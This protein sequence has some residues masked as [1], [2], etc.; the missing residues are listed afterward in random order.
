MP[1]NTNTKY[2]CVICGEEHSKKSVNNNHLKSEK[3]LKNCEILKLNLQMKT[4]DDI[5][6]DYPEYLEDVNK[7][8][9]KLDLINTIVKDKSSVKIELEKVKTNDEVNIDIKMNSN[10]SNKEAL[11]EKIH[12]IHN[13]LRNNGAGYG[14]AALKVFNIFYGL[15]RIEENKLFNKLDLSDECKFSYLLEK[16]KGDDDVLMNI[17]YNQVLESLSKSKLRYFLFYEIPTNMKGKIF[18]HLI[19]ELD[20]LTEIEKSYGE[21]LTGKIYE[22]FIGRDKQAI[23]ELGAYFTN[24]LIVEYIYKQLELEREEDGSIGTMVDPFGGSGGFTTGYINWMKEKYEDI[25]WSSEINKIH[26]YDMNE[27]VIK[28]AALEFF[29]IT[30][31]VPNMEHLQYKNSFTDEFNDQQ[32]KYCITNPPYG[33]DKNNKSDA[34]KK[35]EKIKKYI[36]EELKTLTDKDIIKRRNEQ[37]KHID[38]LNK[39][40]KK[41]QDEQKVTLEKSSKR[42]KKFAK[43]YGLK[44]NDKEAVSLM[45][46]MDMVEEGGVGCGVLKEGV[47]FNKTYKNLRKCLLENYNVTKV[48][49]IPSDQFENT[50]TKTSIVI[51]KNTEEKT[52]SVQFYDLSCVKYDKDKLEEIDGHIVLTENEG[53]VKGVEDKLVSVANVQDI[54]NQKD[55]SLTGK[56]YNKIDIIPGDGY[57]LVRLGDICNLTGRGHYT[58]IGKKEGKYRFY[59]SS[60]NSKLYVDFCDIQELSI[61]LGQG[62][63]FNIH[64]DSNFTPSKHVCVLQLNEKNDNLLKFIYVMIPLIKDKLIVNGS[65]LGWLNN[66]NIKSLKIPIPKDKQTMVEWVNKLSDPKKWYTERIKELEKELQE[67]VQFISE[68]EDCEEKTIGEMGDVSCGSNLPKNKSI[69]GKYKV[70]GGGKSN[71]IHNEFNRN[72]FDILISRVGNNEITLIY[73]DYYLTDNGFGIDCKEKDIKYYIGFYLLSNPLTCGNGSAQ[74]VISKTNLKKIKLKIP[75]NKQLI[76]DMEPQFQ[77]LEQLHI[78]VK[79]ADKKY[80]DLIEEL[81]NEAIKQ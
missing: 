66:A 10:I 78:D 81:K 70:Y 45:L 46:M 19:N 69:P 65:V 37:L 7:F 15:K 17:I 38:N 23:S 35:R 28:S 33:G 13:F 29:C 79:N 74:K 51:F 30:G 2:V 61:I 27:D 43:K 40:E 57:E 50:S 18:S 71:Y 6:M 47:F 60:Q 14:M 9:N 32:Y 64:I 26:H 20:K 80:K 55:I 11:K 72:G 76:Q 22:Y 4:M 12:E 77:E 42:I 3:H 5:L 49:S 59:N 53:D 31:E 21:Q 8:E 36:K 56:E 62:G 1:K 41:R 67:R 63:S 54:L 24:R 52:S 39:L 16:S 34:E 58:S 73:E 75:K 48:I 68:N 25:D 44:G